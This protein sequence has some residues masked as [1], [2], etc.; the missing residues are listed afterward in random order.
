M[1]S[2]NIVVCSWLC[3]E[4]CGWNSEKAGCDLTEQLQIAE[5][6]FDF[7]S[8]LGKH[9]VVL[10]PLTIKR[11]NDI[12]LLNK[13]SQSHTEC[14]LPY[15]FTQCYLPPDTSERA[16]PNPS[17]TGWHSVNLPRMDGRL[18]WPR[19]LGTYET[20]YLSADSHQVVTVPGVEQLTTCQDYTPCSHPPSDSGIVLLHYHCSPHFHFPL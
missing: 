19:W 6:Q 5:S 18:S 10:F 16:P 9:C 15:G 12:T 14:H 7:N 20:V 1:V 13:S 11:L 4:L 8:L 2:Y 17:Q 3:S